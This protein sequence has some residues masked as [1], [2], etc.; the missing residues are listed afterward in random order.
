MRKNVNEQNTKTIAN[1][2]DE[3]V[4]QYIKKY[5]PVNKARI[6]T[7]LNISRYSIGPAIIRLE[8]R[9]WIRIMDDMTHYETYDK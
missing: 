7:A 4:W 9:R 8:E 5:G 6:R 1:K 3:R 2:I